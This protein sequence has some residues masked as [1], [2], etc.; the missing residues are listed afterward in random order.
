M[1]SATKLSFI[2]SFILLGGC[3]AQIPLP[4]NVTITKAGYV[5]VMD[6]IDFSYSPKNN[7]AFSKAKM[8]I[9]ENISNN[10]VTLRDSAGSFVGAYTGTYYQNSNVQQI[11][12]KELFKY[13]DDSS[14]VLIANATTIA[15][16]MF[17]I[18]DVIKFEVKLGINDKNINLV[19]SNIKRAQ[20]NSGSMSNNGFDNVAV[21]SGARSDKIYAHL[22]GISNKI[23]QCLE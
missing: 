22:E 3:A 14:S 12:G 16:T 2:G 17:L 6:K 18:K 23:K 1:L 9:A 11:A 4:S 5:F 10:D 19:F 8:C 15:D 7:V 20:Q 13:V 21:S